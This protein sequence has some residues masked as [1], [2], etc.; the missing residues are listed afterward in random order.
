MGLCL[1]F[2]GCGIPD[3]IGRVVDTGEPLYVNITY[4]AHRDGSLE[5][6]WLGAVKVRDCNIC[7][8]VALGLF[9]DLPI[10]VDNANKC[11]LL[12]SREGELYFHKDKHHR[13]SSKGGK[14]RTRALLKPAEKQ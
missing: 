8:T 3:V 9:L 11:L 5:G 10:H 1:Q 7:A 2:W 12:R 14:S 13:D 6:D 4:K